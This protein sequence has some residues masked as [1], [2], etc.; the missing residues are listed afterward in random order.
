MSEAAKEELPVGE[1]FA[2]FTELLS[3]KCREAADGKATLELQ[4]TR[5]HLRSME[6]LH[7]GV[8]ASLL[9]SAMGHAAGTKA[10]QGHYTVTAQL[11]VNFI[12]PAWEGETLVSTGVVV[13]SGLRTAVTRGEIHTS[14]G[15]LVATGSATF[16]FLPKPTDRAV[17]AKKPD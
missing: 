4:V 8:A 3:L 17:I 11:N 15:Q 6:I 13:H 5:R 7:G 9:D 1:P 2:N 14:T 12:R 10:P 16:L